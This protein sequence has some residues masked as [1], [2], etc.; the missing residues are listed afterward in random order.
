[1]LRCVFNK[2]VVY[3]Q[4]LMKHS[5]VSSL[6]S[7]L[8]LSDQAKKCYLCLL[9][10]K[11]ARARDVAEMTEIH[12]T[13][14]YKPLDELIAA[15]LASEVHVRGVKTYTPTHPELIQTLIDER[16]RHAR[17]ALPSLF[18]E[19]S[20][21]AR[22]HTPR[23]RFHADLEGLRSVME[24]ILLSKD[25]FYRVMG[26]FHDEAFLRALGEKY[27]E[28]WTRRRIA[29]KVHHQTLRPPLTAAH[30][31]ADPSTYEEHPRYLREV[32][33]TALPTN[34]PM[35]TYLYDKKVVFIS[36]RIGSFFAAVIESEDLYTTM[37][38]MFE[39]LWK[40]AGK[41]A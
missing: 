16:S 6:F 34:V 15:G 20:E 38:A 11:T 19:F 13:V 21:T 35:L 41:S 3:L 26:A 18:A 33:F 14:I 5:D 36:G 12:R 37:N 4:Q 40:G 25:K 31:K 30:R 7:L 10:L 28:D 24:E 27:L 8:G 22:T 32:R 17:A 23:I 39:I 1:M 9:R 29:H 2:V